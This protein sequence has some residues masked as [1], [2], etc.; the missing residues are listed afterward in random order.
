MRRRIGI[1]ILASLVAIGVWLGWL[2]T[3]PLSTMFSGGP[4]GYSAHVLGQQDPSRYVRLIE[5]GG[6]TS[7]RVEVR[8]ASVE[9]SQGQFNWTGPDEVVSEAASHHL[10][11]LMIV[12]TSPAWAS[13]ASTLRSNW[14]WL[15][16]RSPVAYGAFAAAVAARYGADGAFWRKYPH[17][18]RYLP[19]GIELWNE[20][21]I[22]KFWAM[23]PPIQRYMRRW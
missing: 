3:R 20:E 4:V 1:V 19:A 22:S 15:P 21:N 9:A 14:L 11:V 5:N 2:N 16:P 18:P 10:N 13:G 23:N 12:D 17:L 7:L 8:W 6:A